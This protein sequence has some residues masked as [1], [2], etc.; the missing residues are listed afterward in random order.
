MMHQNNSRMMER[1]KELQLK[2]AEPFALLPLPANVT[3]FL[4]TNLEADCAAALP[5]NIQ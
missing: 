1:A 4:R 3:N 2:L 5:H